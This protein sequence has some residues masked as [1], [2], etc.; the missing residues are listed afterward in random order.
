MISVPAERFNSEGKVVETVE[1]NML[2]SQNG[3]VVYVYIQGDKL[4]KN[5]MLKRGDWERLVAHV[6]RKT[7]T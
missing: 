7:G 2:D 1:I 3:L 4:S 6:N 5:Y